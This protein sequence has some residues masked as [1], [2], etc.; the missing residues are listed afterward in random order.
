VKPLLILLGF[1]FLFNTSQSQYSESD[2]EYSADTTLLDTLIIDGVQE[3]YITKPF[4]INRN[5][6]EFF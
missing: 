4:L 2:Y 1:Y 5:P 6:I 3:Q